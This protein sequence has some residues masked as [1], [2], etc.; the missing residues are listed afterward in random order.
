[1]LRNHSISI[2]SRPHR[3]EKVWVGRKSTNIFFEFW[4]ACSPKAHSIPSVWSL[5][6]IQNYFFWWGSKQD[7]FQRPLDQAFR[8]AWNVMP[9]PEKSEKSDAYFEEHNK[10]KSHYIDGKLFRCENK[11]K[12]YDGKLLGCH[13]AFLFGAALIGANV[14]G[15][16]DMSFP[17]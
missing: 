6:P 12:R 3:I 7:Q 1:M 14:A 5:G 9:P 8:W 13:R 2:K 10:N 17:P 11:F 16:L 15:G 4:T